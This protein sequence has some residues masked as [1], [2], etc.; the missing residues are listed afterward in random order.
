MLRI[1]TAAVLAP[2][3]WVVLKVAPP[4]L[5]VAVF[6][7]GIAAATL[8]AYRLLQRAGRT[9][10]VAA[11]VLVAFLLAWSFGDIAPRIPPLAVLAAAAAVA[12]LAA[13]TTRLE[14]AAMLDAWTSTL[15]PVFAIAFPLSHTIAIRGFPG[16][17]GADLLLL[18]FVC[19]IFGDTGA[20]YLGS[21]CG[22]RR[23]APSVSPNKSWEGALG[24]VV[25]SLLGALLAVAWF[26]RRL[27][28][29]HAVAL[30]IGL[31]ILGILGDLGESALKRAV[32]AKD[33]STLLPGHGGLLD[34]VDSLLLSAPMLYYYYRLCMSDGL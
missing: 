17:D 20:L 16:D 30:G 27:G 31:G 6:S 7:L 25:A 13:L 26:Y 33:S 32:G 4:W 9:P 2:L 12:M 1:L 22:R 18:L 29:G 8:E 5:F 23:L 11:G 34:R 28:V 24:G 10:H 3:L 19:V 14:P 15:F 21:A